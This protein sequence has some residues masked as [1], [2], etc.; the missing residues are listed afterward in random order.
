MQLRT[1]IDMPIMKPPV[2]LTSKANRPVPPKN[3]LAVVCSVTPWHEAPRIR[4]QI[5]RQLARFYNVIYVE[6]PFFSNCPYDNQEVISHSITVFRPRR[7][8]RGFRRL[9]VNVP[10]FHH[11]YNK[12]VLHKIESVILESGYT[13]SILVNFQFNFAEIMSSRLF[14]ARI[15]YCNDDFP[16]MTANKWKRKLF[17]NYEA[18]TARQSDFCLAVSEPLVLKLAQINSATKLL[19]PGH[20]FDA[21]EGTESSFRRLGSD[22][23]IKVGFMGYVNERIRYDWLELLLKVDTITLVVI[24]PDQSSKGLQI[25]KRYRNFVHVDQLV[26]AALKTAL[27]ALDVLIIPYDSSNQANQAIGAPNKLFQYLACGK[28]VVISDLPNFIKMPPN[29]VYRASSGQE[30]LEMVYRSV[31]E[32]SE[33]LHNARTAYAAI[34]TWNA[35]GNELHKLI[36]SIPCVH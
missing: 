18:E 7:L 4:H 30:F 8:F 2:F 28:P 11:A 15:Y 36:E 25:L 35:R 17:D 33:T 14:N 9:W 22:D 3:R 10:A 13:D 19:L 26:G 34:N 20:E 29:F 16:A 24:G 5:S 12:I 1:V 32:N 31:R 6:L 23:C 27:E 21:I